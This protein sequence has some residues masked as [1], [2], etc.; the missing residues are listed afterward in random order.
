MVLLISLTRDKNRF[1]LFFQLPFPYWVIAAQ[2]QTWSLEVL[3]KHEHVSAPRQGPREHPCSIKSSIINQL[4]DW[5]AWEGTCKYTLDSPRP[6]EELS[7]ISE[8]V[9][10]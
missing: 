3:E 9:I 6:T 2:S 7:V 5:P 8:A 1:I 10:H 4:P